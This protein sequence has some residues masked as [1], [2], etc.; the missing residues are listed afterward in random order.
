MSK[1]VCACT[2]RRVKSAQ[3]LGKMPHVTF[4]AP[5]EDVTD[6]VV[7][8]FPHD[9][10]VGTVIP[11]SALRTKFGVDPGRHR[12]TAE[13]RVNGL[14]AQKFEAIVDA[15]EGNTVAVEFSM[16]APSF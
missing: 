2:W 16:Q 5:A 7:T 11:T 15:S 14:V 3:L 9:G 10:S 1:R 4:V 6:L 12:V 8:F 13:G